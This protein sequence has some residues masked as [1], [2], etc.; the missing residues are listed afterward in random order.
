MLA[1]LLEPSGGGLGGAQAVEEQ[2]A[3]EQRVQRGA[4]ARGGEQVARLR[5][6]DR[7]RLV[8]LLRRWRRAAHECARVRR[9]RLLVHGP[10]VVPGDRRQRDRARGLGE[11]ARGEQREVVLDVFGA[12]RVGGL[13]A[14]GADA[15]EQG[16]HAR[17]EPARVGRALGAQHD[18]EQLVGRGRSVV[19]PRGGGR[20]VSAR[21]SS[22]DRRLSARASSTS[23]A[24][25]AA[26]VSALALK[27]SMFA[28]AAD[29]PAR[30]LN[31]R[32]ETAGAALC[33]C[34]HAATGTRNNV[35]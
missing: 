22:F 28:A 10:P 19:G 20:H 2:Q 11:P 35:C 29:A 18:E 32:Y 12:G 8:L 17:V 3:H 21:S 30:F 1:Q 9:H 33:P 23:C 14:A 27:G 26:W 13:A 6:C 31:A 4:L 34:R 24:R 5:A 7:A 15:E 25:A 16:Q